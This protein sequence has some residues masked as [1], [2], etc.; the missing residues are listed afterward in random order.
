VPLWR[1][2]AGQL[3]N[4]SQLT[5][6][7]LRLL[8]VC[9]ACLGVAVRLLQYCGNRS[10]W[11][12]EAMLS[13]NIL[14]RGV[15]QLARPLADGQAAPY[16][17]L[18]AE[19]VSTALFGPSELVLRLFPVLSSIAALL[20]LWL[21]SIR[22]LN[23]WYRLLVMALA[24]FS[25]QLIYYGQEVK[26]Y[27]TEVAVALGVY[28][29]FLWLG[30]AAHGRTSSAMAL[31]LI[32]AAG[33]WFSFTAGLVIC[34]IGATMLV[35]YFVTR[36]EERSAGRLALV[37]LCWA[38][39]AA[40]LYLVQLR[41]LA[42]NSALHAYWQT[43]FLNTPADAGR[44]LAGLLR[45]GDLVGP[46]ACLAALL[47]LVGVGD[48][49][50]RRALEA[51]PILLIFVGLLLASAM[52]A[53]PLQGRTVLFAVPFVYLLVGLGLAALAPLVRGPY[54]VALGALICL[55][56]LGN[57]GSIGTRPILREE[58]KPLLRVVMA[59]RRSG[60]AVFV[61]RG[62]SRAVAYYQ[63]VWGLKSEG[64]YSGLDG[65]G[66]TASLGTAAIVM[67]QHRR[68]WLLFAHAANHQDEE[69]YLLDRLGGPAQRSY[70]APGAR[71][72][73]YDFGRH[74]PLQRPIPCSPA[75]EPGVGAAS[76]TCPSPPSA[77]PREPHP[78]RP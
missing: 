66:D 54:L 3:G 61:Y 67:S 45:H 69:R 48:L 25:S 47:M 6:R 18:V 37:L 15:G 68:A 23:G 20:L 30:R 76:L 62:A 53:Y 2:A 75:S 24:C 16:L 19:K 31:A 43:G 49:I 50:A 55:P 28:A 78:A 59:Q 40:A 39:S 13:L 9:A 36:R 70:Q 51:L 34:A 11:F 42:A 7:L 14:D 38:A 21:I 44:L 58:T 56:A 35:E 33:M 71:L 77:R 41:D 5:G 10:L 22:L 57:L 52:H 74:N 12:D 72:Y 46:L 63:R 26:Q 29:A 1:L 60:D 65:A 27:S 8:L 4:S 64:W 17:F 32:G 73:L